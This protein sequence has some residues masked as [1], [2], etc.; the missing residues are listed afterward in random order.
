MT[1]DNHVRLHTRWTGHVHYVFDVHVVT[2]ERAYTPVSMCVLPSCYIVTSFDMLHGKA[3]AL[4]MHENNNCDRNYSLSSVK[5][6]IVNMR[7]LHLTLT[8]YLRVKSG[9]HENP[10]QFLQGVQTLKVWHCTYE[11]PSFDPTKLTADQIGVAC[12]P[13]TILVG[14]QTLKFGIV[15]MRGLHSTLAS[16]LRNRSGLH[17]NPKQFL[18][19]VQTLLKLMQIICIFQRCS[20]VSE[21]LR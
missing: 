5:F 10:R 18:V 20:K 13:Y 1:G 21:G 6:G 14:V 16:F 17:A 4:H 8:S 15:N 19:G 7:G 2:K 9:L 11:G 12:K 3:L